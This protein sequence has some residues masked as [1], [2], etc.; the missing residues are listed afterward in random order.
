M[1]LLARARANTRRQ[2]PLEPMCVALAYAA[3][4]TMSTVQCHAPTMFVFVAAA[5]PNARDGDGRPLTT[6]TVIEL[7]RGAVLHVVPGREPLKLL[8]VKAR[9]SLPSPVNMAAWIPERDGFVHPN[10]TV[11][12]TPRRLHHARLRA[13]Y[14]SLF[15]WAPRITNDGNDPIRWKLLEQTGPA[16]RPF[17]SLAHA[18]QTLRRWLLGATL[19]PPKDTLR[20][21][22]AMDSDTY[23]RLMAASDALGDADGGRLP[24]VVRDDGALIIRDRDLAAIMD[25]ANVA[26]L[27]AHPLPTTHLGTLPALRVELALLDMRT[28]WPLAVCLHFAT[29]HDMFVR[30]ADRSLC[31]IEPLTRA[32]AP[33]GALD[34][35][36]WFQC[37][38]AL[39]AGLQLY[40]LHVED[41]SPADFETTD[42]HGTPYGY[43]NWAFRLREVDGYYVIPYAVH[44]NRMLKVRVAKPLTTLE[45]HAARIDATRGQR[46]RLRAF[47]RSM[48]SRAGA[49]IALRTAILNEATGAWYDFGKHPY[50]EGTVQYA[51]ATLAPLRIHIAA[52]IQLGYRRDLPALVGFVPDLGHPAVPLVEGATVLKRPADEESSSDESSSSS[53]F[54]FSD[55][56]PSPEHQSKRRRPNSDSDDE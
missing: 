8:L 27:R 22:A 32:I 55:D 19:P 16:Y 28:R 26:V 40:E 25:G 52:K 29:A 51:P 35:S 37:L 9:H 2:Q 42:M 34:A 47:E 3:T 14:P 20:D 43:R 1:D 46:T 48:L 4:D 6:D 39:R 36:L 21:D 44:Q 33:V 31:T 45:I 41:L 38:F 54:S 49:P 10:A 30:A 17:L 7:T 50:F 13:A 5:A 56:E 53:S 12:T 23:A 15:R 24:W 11:E 18:R